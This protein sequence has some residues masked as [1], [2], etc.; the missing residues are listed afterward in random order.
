ME[1]PCT[2]T[3]WVATFSQ[4]CD[5][6]Y[7]TALIDQVLCYGRASQVLHLLFQPSQ[8]PAI[9]SSTRMRDWHVRM[10]NLDI[11]TKF[12]C[13]SGQRLT[14]WQGRIARQ[15]LV[16]AFVLLHYSRTLNVTTC[17]GRGDFATNIISVKAK[18]L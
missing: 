2:I 8:S 16:L 3:I 18:Y 17:V 4:S 11:Q 7:I 1:M 6:S 9:L 13:D 15:A 12:A 10:L 14:T 5:L